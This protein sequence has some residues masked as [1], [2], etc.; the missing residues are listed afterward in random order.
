MMI[1]TLMSV[2]ITS[3]SDIFAQVTLSCNNVINYCIKLG[4]AKAFGWGGGGAF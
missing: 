3:I 4:D 2:V 1:L